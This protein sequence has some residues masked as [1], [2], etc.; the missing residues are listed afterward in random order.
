MKSKTLTFLLL[1]L[2]GVA[3]LNFEAN[4]EPEGGKKNVKN[5]ISKVTGNP[6]HTFLNINNIS[7]VIKNTGISDINVDE[8]NSGL[9]FPKGS[10]KQAM[11][12]AGLLWGAKIAGDDNPRVGGSAYRT[13]LQPGNILP[14]GSPDDPDKDIHRI[15]RVRPD[16]YPGGPDVDL[17][18]AASI[19]GN[20][21]DAI[22][23]Q[24]EADWTEWPASLGAPYDDV[25]GNGSYDPNVDVPGVAGADQTIWY[26]AND[27]DPSKS[28]Y[29]YGA[30]PLGVEMQ[31][32]MWAYAQQGALGN[33]YFRQ[34]KIINKSSNTFEDMYVSMF[35]D[36]DVGNSADDFVG[37]DT[38]LSLGYAYNALASDGNYAPLP[39]P[40]IGFDFFQG[41][42][43]D[44]APT[45]VAIIDVINQRKVTGKKNLPMTAFYYFARGDAAVT[46]PTQG[47]IEGSQ[48]F[49]NFFQ[50]RIGKTG[51]MFTDPHTLT[52]TP[53]VMPGDPQT[54]SGWLDGDILPM[55]DRRMGSASGPFNMAPN[56]TQVVVV[57]E[58]VAG[59]IPG[60]DRLA[61]IGLLK[62]Y[63]QQAQLAYDNFFDLP[64]APKEPKVK[65]VELDRE[66]ILD[67]SWD[68]DRIAETEGSDLKGFKFQGYNVYQL[69]TAAA[70]FEE[71]KRVATYDL[72]DGVGKIEDYFFDPNTGVVAIGVKQFGNDTGIKR[73]ISIENDEINGGTPLINGTKYYYAVTAYSYNEDPNAVPNNLE[74]PLTVYTVTP[75]SNNPGDRLGA[76]FGANLVDVSHSGSADGQIEVSVV[77][78]TALTGNQYEVSFYDKLFYR[79]QNGKWKPGDSPNGVSY[80]LKPE[81]VSP[82]SIT[83]SAA[84][85]GADAGTIDIYFDVDV[86]SPDGNWID[87][88]LMTFPEGTYINA[89]DGDCGEATVLDNVVFY[90][91]SSRS[92]G[93]CFAGGEVV[94][95]NVQQYAAPFSVQYKMYDDAWL[96]YYDSTATIIDAEGQVSV[97]TNFGYGVQLR[98]LWKVTDKT[99]GST[100][101]EDQFV[102][103]GTDAYEGSDP[104]VNAAPVI[105]GFQINPNVSFSA[106]IDFTPAGAFDSPD[107]DGT[108]VTTGS[109]HWASGDITSYGFQH[110]AET[111]MAFHTIGTGTTDINELQKDYELR[112]TGE[113]ETV[114][115]VVKIKEGTGSV[116]TLYL[117]RE[118]D[119]ADH[120]LNPNPGSSDP[121][122][123]RI[124]FEVW[125]VDDD[126]QVN[127]YVQHRN[128]TPADDPFYVWNES[129]RMYCEI[130]NTP[131][132]ETLLTDDD[133]TN[134]TWNL[135]FWGTEWQK[136]DVIYL[137][138]DNPIQK[139]VDSYTFTTPA[140]TYSVET[141]KDDIAKVNVFPNP[142]YAVNTEELNKYNRFVTFSH[143]PEKATIRIFNLAGV[144]VKTI[145]KDNNDQFQRWN[146]ANDSGFPVASGLYI[147]YIDMPD[148]GEEVILKL[149]IIQEQQ[150]LDRF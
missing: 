45:D 105:D 15:Y 69:P 52:K 12:I 62:F 131:Y 88:L 23:A 138:Y 143:L 3:F 142:Y 132:K 90:G 48:Q 60:V 93:G 100:V 148:L 85:Y 35:S 7:T 135:V 2:I 41:P 106:P 112:F 59:A 80:S 28:T 13:G 64:T 27:M 63:D 141:A 79:D 114:N 16:I 110:W 113:R 50:G 5:V 24:Y 122:T 58:I 72:N 76:E 107:G 116:A 129:G 83:Q 149:A 8:D 43:V 33:M 31:A 55:G 136:G 73:Y 6:P 78:P 77:D 22:R 145:E 137:K 40:A 49:Y 39:P 130:V 125:N 134:A 46:D 94:R 47:D 25:D 97:S 102:L 101:I 67:W 92:G 119:I 70:S 74:N 4:A 20:A 126:Q 65:T 86:V 30:Q 66:I 144:H 111:A 84:I 109:D 17:S 146:L 21:E 18:E 104:G 118:Y 1:L 96:T 32:T 117:A 127:M 57:A 36:P 81:D 120:P 147:A 44:G 38:T 121:F 19:E 82:S 42:V 87:G 128:G 91:D 150:I 75:H 99:T 54:R 133:L 68:K 29:L 61:A 89:A 56:D 123:I 115:G 95:V 53:F 124:P 26:V 9:E 11:Y 139:G 98:N 71:G 37:S 34:Y 140:P 10:G 14:N 108:R 103:N 51:A